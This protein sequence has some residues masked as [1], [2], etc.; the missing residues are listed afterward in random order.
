KQLGSLEVCPTCDNFLRPN[1][2]FFGEMA[3][4][5]QDM[6]MEFN[7]CEVLVIIGTSGA[8]INTDMFL[9]PDIKISILN[10]IEPSDYLME[11]LYTKVL[12]K[13]ATK[14]I[15]EIVFDIEEFLTNGK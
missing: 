5:Y 1:I 2:V 11:E 6:F 10:N 3:P 4:K 14:A 15:D 9:N 12:H 13:E 7:D 8:V